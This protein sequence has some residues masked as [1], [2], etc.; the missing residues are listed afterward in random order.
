MNAVASLPDLTF[1]G[2]KP[3]EAEAQRPGYKPSV[4][5]RDITEQTQAYGL[6]RGFANRENIPLQFADR[7]M[8]EQQQATI[9]AG[10]TK[11]YRHWMDQFEHT[12]ELG[13]QA[14]IE[15]RS[16]DEMHLSKW[17]PVY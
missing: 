6:A 7:A 16:I 11:L 17:D 10:N 13:R 4:S 15:Q 8:W 14:L 12:L 2:D 3:E 5:S 1:T 9:H